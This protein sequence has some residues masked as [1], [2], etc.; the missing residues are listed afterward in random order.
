MRQCDFPCLAPLPDRLLC[1]LI[2][3]ILAEWPTALLRLS[4]HL[5]FTVTCKPAQTG[6]AHNQE[7]GC[8]HL[9][10]REWHSRSHESKVVLKLFGSLLCPP[11]LPSTGC[12]RDSHLFQG[13][14]Q[15]AVMSVSGLVRPDWW[16]HSSLSA[17]TELSGKY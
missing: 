13:R 1:S 6:G 14:T 4:N 5:S 2:I 8:E 15:A 7:L 3:C 17:W 16:A 10:G 11:C 9:G 12:H